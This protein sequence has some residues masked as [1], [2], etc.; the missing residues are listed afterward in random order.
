MSS[1]VTRQLA[2][3]AVE[4]C[5]Q[6][7]PSGVHG[8][9]KLAIADAAGTVLAGLNERPVMLLRDMVVAD[10]QAGRASVFGC[11]L[12]L[13]AAGAALANA[14]S[15]H[16]L[17]YD[18]ISL[19]VVGFIASPV[20]F[21]LLAVAEE[22]GGVSGRDLLESFVIGWEVEAAIARGLGVDHYA[23]GWH[24]TS[25]LAHFGAAVAVGRLLKLDV[26]RMRHAIGIAAS[27]ASG[28]RTMIGNMVNPFHVGKAARNGIVAARLAQRGF[29]AHAS[30]LETGWGFC[31]AFNGRGNYD[32]D[33]MLDRLGR[34]YDLVDPGLVIK[35]YPCCGLIHSALDGV[36]DLMRQHNLDAAQVGRACIAVHELV[37][38]TMCFDRPQTGYQAK[39]SAPF[40]IATALREG[41]VRLAHFTD[42]RVRDPQMQ[43]LMERV[44]MAVHPELRGY[45]TFLQKEFTDV[46]LELA[47]G[48]SVECR[49]WRMNNRGSRGR[50][51]TLEQL[52]E[53]FH[54]CTAAYRD[55]AMAARAFEM[56]AGLEAV[57]DVREVTACLR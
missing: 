4:T 42:E 3:F 50:P 23:R 8:Q 15:A 57:S 7:I 20:L 16:A 9:A 41:A 52:R 46:T 48:G 29:T 11:D 30:V 55:A 34:P 28:L 49:A 36:L 18:S 53:K 24:S 5:Y 13:T 47:R 25:T 54:D 44:E 37:P 22:E 43:Q 10:F 12:R 45:Q 14:A 33:A 19:S 38:P 31:T 26:T 40:C 56:L 17:D 2:E 21:A 27:E 39:F 51:V 35:V 6:D 1:E 32:L